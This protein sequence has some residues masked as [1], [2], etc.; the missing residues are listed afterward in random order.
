MTPRNKGYLAF[1][2]RLNDHKALFH[3]SRKFDFKCF[4][5]GAGAVT[6][7]GNMDL[8]RRLFKDRFHA[9]LEKVVIGA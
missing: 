1:S 8:F 6:A 7:K 3:V 5:T 2:V 9:E 4:Y